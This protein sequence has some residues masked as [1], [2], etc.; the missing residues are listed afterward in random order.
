[1]PIYAYQCAACGETFD[2]IVRLSAQ[3]STTAPRIVCPHCNS[4]KVKKLV[5][6]PRVIGNDFGESSAAE[7]AADAAANH[8]GLFG[9]KEL[10]EVTRKRKK[11]GL[12]A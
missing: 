12:A 3:P 6:A 1:M 11:N 2:K 4:R 10:N 8:T 7:E 5:S 9:R